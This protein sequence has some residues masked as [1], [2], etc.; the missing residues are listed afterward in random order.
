MKQN[1]EYSIIKGS[2]I[3]KVRKINNKLSRYWNIASLHY[4]LP[5][6]RHGINPLLQYSISSL[7][8]LK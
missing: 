5:A 1:S 4:S 8:V 2:P 6:G 3:G 7:K